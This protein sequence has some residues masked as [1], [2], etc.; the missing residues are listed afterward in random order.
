M[1][2]MCSQVWELRVTLTVFEFHPK[3]LFQFVEQRPLKHFQHQRF[4]SLPLWSTS[5]LNNLNHYEVLFHVTR[6]WQ[7][8]FLSL[9]EEEVIRR[10]QEIHP[11]VC[12]AWKDMMISGLLHTGDSKRK[13]CSPPSTCHA[14]PKAYG[15]TCC[16]EQLL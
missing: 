8:P 5:Y 11:T 12:N 4:Q 14:S 1:I 10:I 9:D 13:V 16:L 2:L 7:V 3:Y 6:V 15:S